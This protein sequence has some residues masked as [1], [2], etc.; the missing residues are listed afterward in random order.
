MSPNLSRSGAMI[1]R[2]GI[3][4]P[5][6]NAGMDPVIVIL[7]SV[8]VLAVCGISFCVWRKLAPEA[9]RSLLACIPVPPQRRERK[10]D[11]DPENDRPEIFDA[12]TERCAPNGF[13]W[14]EYSVRA[15][16][17]VPRVCAYG[18]A[19]P[20]LAF[21]RDR[22]DRIWFCSES[23]KTWGQQRGR[24]GGEREKGPGKVPPKS[25]RPCCNAVATSHKTLRLC[26]SGSIGR[27]LAGWINYWTG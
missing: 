12:W 8:G 14:E 21:L 16:P 17:Y 23:R 22:L 10:N 2:A 25:W 5:S 7:T 9:F 26:G 3:S 15:P 13:N 20:P 1:P 4:Q 24:K 18:A 6:P 19:L 27:C 11:C